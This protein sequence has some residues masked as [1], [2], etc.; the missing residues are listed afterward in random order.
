[1]RT[2]RTAP[3]RSAPVEEDGQ[4]QRAVLARAQRVPLARIEMD[5]VAGAELDAA[6]RLQD[7]RA[8][9]AV[10]GDRSVD[11]VR[12]SGDAAVRQMIDE[13]SEADAL[14]LYAEV[15]A[16]LEMSYVEP[17]QMSDIS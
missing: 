2:F 12:R 14:E 9:Q 13:V 5:P 15:L 8:F 6:A 7:H 1:M 17:V 3:P 11:G 4:Q 16:R 10:E